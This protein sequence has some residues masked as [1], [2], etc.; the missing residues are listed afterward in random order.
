MPVE[1]ALVAVFGIGA[2]DG[3]AMGGGTL[4]GVV[5]G[6]PTRRTIW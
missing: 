4:V 3:A 2:G 6:V 1:A 5:V